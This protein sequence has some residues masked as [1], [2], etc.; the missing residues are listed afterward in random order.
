M[1]IVVTLLCWV[2]GRQGRGRGCMKGAFA[3]KRKGG[4]GENTKK[5]ARHESLRKTDETFLQ[6]QANEHKHG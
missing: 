3:G 1:A 5:Y 4:R 2:G 6:K